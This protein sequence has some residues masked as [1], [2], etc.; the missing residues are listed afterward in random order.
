[1]SIRNA[2]KNNEKLFPLFRRN[3]TEN[4]VNLY[5]ATA[6][7][8]ALWAAREKAYYP[9]ARPVIVEL[10]ETAH[11]QVRR[12]S[13]APD[14]PFHISDTSEA[15]KPWAEPFVKLVST[16][17]HFYF[18]FAEPQL[19]V[20]LRVL[21][22][23]INIDPLAPDYPR[24]L[25]QHPS[26]YVV[27]PST[28]DRVAQSAS[29]MSRG[30]P[31]MTPGSSIA[32]H[33]GATPPTLSAV[34]MGSPAAA[35]PLR[36]PVQGGPS[37]SSTTPFPPPRNRPVAPPVSINVPLSL[38]QV[39]QHSPP[40]FSPDPSTP[41]VPAPMASHGV[42]PTNAAASRAEPSQS[43]AVAGPSSVA[44]T[45]PTVS[46]PTSPAI[47]AATSG[48]SSSAAPPLKR[49]LKKKKKRLTEDDFI[50]ADLADWESARANK[51][52]QPASPALPS[53]E[54]TSRA[55]SASGVQPEPQTPRET[56]G[57]TAP[58][59]S[60]TR[61]AGMSETAGASASNVVNEFQA[62]SSAAPDAAMLKQPTPIST[63]ETY[64]PPEP[65][66]EPTPATSA[67]PAVVAEPAPSTPVLPTVSPPDRPAEVD[68]RSQAPSSP[69]T[70]KKKRPSQEFRFV[71]QNGMSP[72]STSVKRK[73]Q[74]PGLVV[75]RVD[76]QPHPAN[77][78]ALEAVN[79]KEVGQKVGDSP[80]TETVET[81]IVTKDRDGE[82]KRATAELQDSPMLED[83]AAPD[84]LQQHAACREPQ[85]EPTLDS[86]ELQGTLL[87]PA[88]YH[89]HDH[90]S[91]DVVMA[92]LAQN[93]GGELVGPT[94]QPMELDGGPRDEVPATGA[95]NDSA[96]DVVVE[97]A[98]GQSSD[99][100]PSDVPIDQ[101]MESP[102]EE[103]R[104]H[105]AESEALAPVPVH[106]QVHVVAKT[107]WEGTSMEVDT[108]PAV[109]G[110]QST[111]THT[112]AEPPPT[113]GRPYE[114]IMQELAEKKGMST[115]IVSRIVTAAAEE[116]E[117]EVSM[118]L[119]RVSF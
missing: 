13:H 40:P 42:Q 91:E 69:R 118:H 16:V 67:V 3:L 66:T 89:A 101:P 60:D 20:R 17:A 98:L 70:S 81:D 107:L 23:T 12:H 7:K 30:S 54:P 103:A 73:K 4:N 64:A 65:A 115:D 112:L 114:G 35:S 102:V 62:S 74:S 2:E 38:Q 8:L 80:H 68:L 85:Q 46:A 33:S 58:T 39:S 59:A 117:P 63:D 116:A 18:L 76:P 14:K 106:P 53:V 119:F 95:V 56:H 108:H 111:A 55:C 29:P 48:E 72:K 100:G 26:P 6:D 61:I 57:P 52:A 51:V 34:E 25:A 75:L 104:A 50:M 84:T 11:A 43:A 96:M 113:V 1:M 47:A 105:V 10:L 37:N 82:P 9:Y 44:G 86:G 78:N 36:Y 110:L 90:L 109:D 92:D 87:G 99:S 41:G 71:S 31:L 88:P 24:Q 27:S 49:K 93:P 28:T 94:A 32:A 45:S 21:L 83:V 77:G 22:Q 79:G 5:A 19:Q 97:D 15:L